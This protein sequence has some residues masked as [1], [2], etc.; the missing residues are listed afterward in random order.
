MSRCRGL[1]R[2]ST[3]TLRRRAPLGG[4]WVSIRDPYERFDAVKI[5][6]GS[7]SAATLLLAATLGFGALALAPSANA[8]PDPEF[9]PNCDTVPT[10][11]LIDQRGF[12][13]V[14]DG[15]ASPTDGGW[16]RRA[17]LWGESNRFCSRGTLG[18]RRCM[19]MLGGMHVYNTTE[20]VVFPD[21]IPPGEPG[22]LG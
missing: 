13:T 6:A 12:R 5:L 22:H 18:N 21:A 10:G 9:G 16:N 11:S 14:C 17:I 7:V 19:D 4:M 3:P 20:Y 8:Y 2:Y 1:P 15:P